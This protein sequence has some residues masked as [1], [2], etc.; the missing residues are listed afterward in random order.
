[1]DLISI[2]HEPPAFQPTL[3]NGLFFTVSADTS[4]K[5]K[6]R[7]TYDL[8]VEGNMVYQ[9]KATPNPFGL[10]I[11]DMS[12]ILKTY[13]GNNPIAMWNNTPIY[14]HQTFP[15][16]RPYKPE[17]INYQV[18][19]GFEYS[20]SPLGDVTGFTGVYTTG[21]T[22][23]NPGVAAPLKKVFQSTMGV[24]GRATQQD[25]NMDPFVLSGSPV[26]FNPTRSGLYL[27]NSPRNRNI[28]ETEYYTLSFT[29]WYMS[30]SMLSEP[31]Y[32]QYKFYDDSGT[33]LQTTN[34]ENVLTNGGGP[35][36]DCTTV[37]QSYL[38]VYSTGATAFNTL[39]VGAGPKNLDAIMPAGTK[40]Y[41]VQ[42]FGHF[43]GSTSPIIPTPTPTPTPSSTPSVCACLEYDIENPS[44]ESLVI[45]SYT[46][47]DKI[48]RVIEIEP[49]ASYRICVCNAGNWS[50]SGFLNITYIGS[51]IPVSPTPTPNPSPTPTPGTCVCEQVEITNP[52]A[53]MITVTGFDCYGDG[54]GIV[55]NANDTL[56][57][58]FCVCTNT[59]QS[60]FFFIVTPL[61]SCLPPSPTPTR[62]STPTPTPTPTST[63]IPPGPP[64]TYSINEC[65]GGCVG[66]ECTCDFIGIQNVYMAPGFNPADE[67]QN[68]YSDPGLTTLW[69]GFYSYAGNIYE[70][71]A[72]SFVCTIGGPC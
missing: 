37:Y 53:F 14:T 3:A 67:G 19:F 17:T 2:Q 56:E 24:N 44:L 54:V 46:D 48:T 39:Y 42:L 63:P 34:I 13:C 31:Y 72:I 10:G 36:P 69:Y 27:T 70:A 43:T 1:M 9:G 71:S 60:E 6:F 49:N 41:T 38:G 66:G 22:E 55:V 26:G 33:L 50:Y 7:Y 45:F 29:N 5:Y 51:C 28:Q 59:L 25:F 52:N 35:R 18:Y 65:A 21:M 62:T 32:V 30:N 4:N 47:C 61:A 64:E 8:Y 15:F 23:G 58:P 12:R 11:L 57:V 16:S 68:I 40:Q 20:S